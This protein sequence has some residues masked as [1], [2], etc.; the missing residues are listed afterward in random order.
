MEAQ[1]EQMDVKQKVP[2]ILLEIFVFGTEENKPA[3]KRLNDNLQEQMS[4]Q[5]KNKNRVRILWYI[6]KGE[7]TIE[8]KKQ[9]LEE[10]ANCKYFIYATDGEKYSIPS[11]FVRSTL[12]KIKKLEDAIESM[13]TSK[14]IISKKKPVKDE[15]DS[16]EE[17]K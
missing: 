5:R 11:D 4:K 2:R 17:V 14:I 12:I 10:N 7:K 1:N 16:Y 9:W 6:D 3:I 13:K 8:E 15:F